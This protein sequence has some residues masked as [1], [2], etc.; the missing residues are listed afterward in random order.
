V[1]A[2]Y[3]GVTLFLGLSGL[4]LP[5]RLLKLLVLVAFAVL[6]AVGLAVL[7]RRTETGCN[8]AE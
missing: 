4:L 1:L 3:W 6:T 5:S 7:A 8:A 2:L